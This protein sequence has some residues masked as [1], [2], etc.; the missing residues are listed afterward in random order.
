MVAAALVAGGC[1]RRAVKVDGS[2]TV[3]PITEAVGEVFREQRPDVHIIGGRAGTGGGFKKFSHGEIDICNAS[4][5]ISDVEKEACDKNGIE[6]VSFIIAFDGLSICVNPKNDWCDCI[7]V[8]QLKAIWQPGSTVTKWSD[9]DPKWPEHE[10]KLYGPGLDSGTFDFFTKAIVGE[11]KKSRSDFVQSEDDNVLVMGVS[12]DANSLGYF[13]LAYY[14][15]N[16][17][18][19]KLLAVDPGDGK[20]LKPSQESVLAGTYKPLSRPLFIYVRKDSLARPDVRAFV[21]FF[22]QNVGN[23]VAKTGYVATSQAIR[24]ENVALLKNMLSSVR[25]EI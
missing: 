18:R 10:I 1:A 17:T 13:G 8:E 4:R 12:G 23:E 7:T 22:V 3:L 19:L 14:E 16:R 24:G 5:P 25:P 11:E 21:E 9:L 20:C 2:S 6:Y 15:N